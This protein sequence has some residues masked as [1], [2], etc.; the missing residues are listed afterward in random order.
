M[1]YGEESGW[2]G[3]NAKSE[4]IHGL[5]EVVPELVLLSEI[6]KASRDWSKF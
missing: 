6:M 4:E 5:P 3:K 1:G 2:V